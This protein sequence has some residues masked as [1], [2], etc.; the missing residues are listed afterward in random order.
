[1]LLE[2]LEINEVLFSELKIENKKFRIDDEYFNKRF[3]NA[4]RIIKGKKYVRFSTIIEILTDFHSNG[5]YEAIA[6]EF[7]L[8]DSPNYAYMVRTT[9]LET[10]NYSDNVKYVTKECYNFLSKSKVYGGE[11]LINKIGAPGRTYLMPYLNRPVSLGMNLFMIRLKKDSGFNESFLYVFFNTKIGERV[12]FRKVNG[13]VPLTIDKESIKSL[14][15]PCLSTDFQLK[16]EQ[17]V[18]SSQALLVESKSI[19]FEAE[20][21]L[22][23]EL[24]L[25][26]W[27]PNNNP[28]N[29]KQL[30]ESFLASGRLDAEYYQSKYE[31][32]EK[33]IKYNSEYLSL[34][35][36]FDILSN[37]S[38]KQY[39][40]E[41]IKVIKTRNIRIPSIEY[42]TISDCTID[43]CL[44]IQK[45]DL[46]FASMGVG[47]LGRMSYVFDTKHDCTI[48]GTI[49]L[50]RTKDKYKDQN[51]EIP[52][53]LFLTSTIGQELIYKNVI[54]STG[55][56]SI[57]KESI[58]NL[59]VP[60]INQEKRIEISNMVQKSFAL[61]AESK[62]LLDEA[63]MMVEKEIENG[64]E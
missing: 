20:D 3:V 54:G 35:E 23:S 5:S 37:P 29:I 59:I 42:D 40:N 4:E 11:L 6:K 30:K 28:V 21:L 57:S 52:T 1:M 19:Y 49:K 64:G 55:I 34:S 50:L 9:D 25:K 51:W 63:K 18:K 41:G 58:E 17:K 22:L 39:Y 2:G 16:T 44:K 12:I 48:D 14:S 13:T 26:G 24:G 27:Q 15:I 62:R 56:I 38:P 45:D 61:K 10:E 31:E 46:L 47:S 8:L 7:E 33:I 43:N 32:I 36:L 53:L 60:I